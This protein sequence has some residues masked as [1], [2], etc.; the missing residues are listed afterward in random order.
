MW[1]WLLRLTYF[2]TAT[3]NLGILLPLF[4]NVEKVVFITCKLKNLIF[5]KV[6]GNKE[7]GVII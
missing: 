6:S 3:R 1:W 5:S 4:L 2:H 7:E